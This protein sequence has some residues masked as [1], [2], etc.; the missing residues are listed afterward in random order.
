MALNNV[1]AARDQLENSQGQPLAGALIYLYEP[2]TTTFIQAF[3]DAALTLPHTAPIKASG[4]GR[5]NIWINRD[6]DLRIEDRNGNLILTEDGVNPDALGGGDVGGLLQNGGFEDDTNS[7]GTPDFWVLLNDAGS[8]N[9]RD[10]SE[11]T[12]GAASFRFTS[13]GTGG[14]SLTTENFF[15]VNEVDDLRVTFD[16]RST[17]AAVRNIVRIEWFDVSQIS[18]SDTDVYDSTANPLT[19]TSFTLDGTPPVGARFAK[20]RLIGIDPS[21]ALAGSTYF[22]NVAA[23]YPAVVAGVFDNIEIRNNEIISTNTNGEID[24]K[25]DGT[26]PVNVISSN[27]VDLVDVNNPLNIAQVVP[28]ATNP[29]I[30]I[31]SANIQAK[32]DATTLAALNL[33]PLGGQ[34]NILSGATVGSGASLSST[35]TINTSAGTDTILQMQ[36][37]G[38][39]SANLTYFGGTSVTR[40]T[41]DGNVEIFADSILAMTFDAGA[42]S[43]STPAGIVFNVEDGLNINAG[44]LYLAE[45]SAGADFANFGQIYVNSSNEPIFRD[46]GGT[47]TNLL[48]S[49]GTVGI[50]G[51]PVDNQI[52]VWTGAT[53]IE[54]TVGLVYNNT[55]GNPALGGQLQL[56]GTNGALSIPASLAVLQ[57]M[58]VANDRTNASAAVFSKN[59]ANTTDHVVGILLQNRKR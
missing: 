59:V 44:S 25:P 49:G 20:I 36:Q 26:G 47:E 9:A 39:N 32:A 43:V 12:E 48:T 35:L 54:G 18:I 56:T 22:D 51:T 33:Q 37:N 40:L 21:V 4:S 11:S 14:G 16:L 34:V 3:K 8:T 13:A 10:T 45:V 50:D 28:A 53:N 41:G 57:T 52:A 15:P 5:A 17:V 31:D 1:I 42:S 2:G 23:F 46:E 19:Y 30:A 29:H 38:V 24:I 7:D 58:F 27:A 55:M 6:A